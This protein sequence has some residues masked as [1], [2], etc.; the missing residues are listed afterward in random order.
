M[1]AL[2]QKYVAPDWTT[3]L[4]KVPS[5]YLKLALR[6]TPIHPWRLHGV[7]DGFSVS[8]KR[9]DLTGCTLSGNKVRKLEFLLAEAVQTG[10][11]C[12]V[13]CGGLQSNFC[14]AAAVASRQIGLDSHLFLRCPGNLD[15]SK[16][17]CNGNLLL[18]R[19]VG[20]NVFLVPPLSYEGKTNELG[21]VAGLKDKMSTYADKLRSSG[22]KPYNMPVGGSNLTGMWGYIEAFRELL[23]QGVAEQ[24]D[25]IVFATGSGGTASGLSIANYL[26]GS[27]LK[28]HAVAVCDNANYFYDHVGDTLEAIGMGDKVKSTDIL[29]VVDGYK[30]QGYGLTTDKDLRQLIEIA[31]STGIVLDPTYTL[32][33]VQGLLGELKK[34][35]TR[36]KGKR[37]LHIHTG[38]I[39]GL[40]DGRITEILKSTPVTN[41]ITVFSEP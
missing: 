35:P 5:T 36:F 23:D 19:L 11:N 3:C 38:G 14:R 32:K 39:F 8:I 17:Q 37:I 10:C 25:D 15:P 30:G 18:D 7:P 41:R 22:Q 24:Y 12:V 6:P 1:S 31:S 29:D 9:D 34:N 40:Y 16:A 33:G 20:A 26:T 28:I 27:K 13:T 21:Y 4:N 2:L